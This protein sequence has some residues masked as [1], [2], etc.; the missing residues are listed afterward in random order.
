MIA[1]DDS[2]SDESSSCS[3]LDLLCHIITPIGM[4]G[5]GYDESQTRVALQ[6]LSSSRAPVAIIAD[7][8]STDGGPAKLATGKTSCPRSAYIRD[9]GRLLVLAHEFNVPVLTSSCGGDGTNDHVDDYV[10]IIEEN[11]AVHQNL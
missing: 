7:S 11:V 9:L 8:G 2:P 4:L 5:Y 6:E 1:K 10:K 3:D